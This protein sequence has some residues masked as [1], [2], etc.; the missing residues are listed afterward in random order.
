MDE[1]FYMRLSWRNN[2]EACQNKETTKMI[3]QW[4]WNCDANLTH[5]WVNSPE[6]HLDLAE[7]FSARLFFSVFCNLV[8]IL[9]V[10]P[11]GSNR[12]VCCSASCNATYISKLS[13]CNNPVT[14]NNKGKK[15]TKNDCLY[16]LCAQTAA[17][18]RV[19][20]V[21]LGEIVML[22]LVEM[23]LWHD[24]YYKVWNRLILKIG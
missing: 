24:N 12:L 16:L 15:N 1:D 11:L 17:V 5:T 13:I 14:K 2:G 19:K 8:S 18:I 20:F 7:T 9:R 23:S 6:D 21:V 22:E 4:W 3:T 10:W